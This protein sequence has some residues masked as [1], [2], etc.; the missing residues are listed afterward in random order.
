MQS[1]GTLV[2]SARTFKRLEQVARE[3][4]RAARELE[5]VEQSDLYGRYVVEEDETLDEDEVLEFLRLARQIYPTQELEIIVI[6][7]SA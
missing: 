2:R 4:L 3:A 6:A 1:P 7:P 5:R